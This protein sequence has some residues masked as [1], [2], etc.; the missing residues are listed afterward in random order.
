[1][2]ALRIV[3]TAAAAA[4]IAAALLL[5]EAPSPPYADGYYVIDVSGSYLTAVVP[6]SAGGCTASHPAGLPAAFIAP[7]GWNASNALV[8]EK[9]PYV[10]RLYVNGTLYAIYPKVVYGVDPT[11]QTV[12]AAVPIY[13]NKYERTVVGRVVYYDSYKYSL[14]IEGRVGYVYLVDPNEGAG[15]PILFTE[16]CRLYYAPWK[17]PLLQRKIDIYR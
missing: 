8:L 9:P 12:Y 16:R 10:E 3:T 17:A 11:T 15:E 5:V 1:M 7:P 2:S 14:Y 4:V 6:D 13:A